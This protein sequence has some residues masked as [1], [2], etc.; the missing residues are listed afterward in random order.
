MPPKKTKS[1]SNLNASGENPSDKNLEQK[2]DHLVRKKDALESKLHRFKSFLNNLQSITVDSSKYI[3]LDTRLRDLEGSLLSEYSVIQ[4]ELEAID[5]EQYGE[6]EEGSFESNYYTTIS[7][8]K[9]LLIALSN[10]PQ[11]QAPMPGSNSRF[12]N[13]SKHSINVKLPSIELPK[14]SGL[15]EKWY[16]FKELYLSLIHNADFLDS[17][18]KF[19][20]L[21]TSL[22]GQALQCIKSIDLSGQNYDIAWNLLCERYNNK[23]LI[24]HKHIKSLFSLSEVKQDSS[25]SIR[26]LIDD[27][28]KNLHSLENMGIL[29]DSWDPLIIY[30]VTSKLDS[31]TIRYWEQ[32]ELSNELPTLAELKRFLSS[33]ADYLEKIDLHKIK[34]KHF[35]QANS[36]FVPKTKDKCFSS[37]EKES[38]HNSV[39]NSYNK[40]N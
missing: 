10:H 27:L 4:V 6:E 12:S 30:L 35:G 20:Y 19:H 34:P 2:T 17:V 14:F 18:Q 9:Q 33:R 24:I 3:E 25:I 36:H 26:S 1:S 37:I 28:S 22:E 39:F 7:E 5:L 15:Y 31:E 29:T 40:T 16:E 13:N 38:Q 21:R 11:T 8:A 23:R 32:V